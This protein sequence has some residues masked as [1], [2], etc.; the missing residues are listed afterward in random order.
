MGRELHTQEDV[1]NLQHDAKFRLKEAWTN[2][3]VYGS[4]IT[5]LIIF[6]CVVYWLTSL[7]YNKEE[8][9]IGICRVTDFVIDWLLFIALNYL[10][11]KHHKEI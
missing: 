1:N 11:K 5:A 4:Y 9:K 10:R 8:I 2:I 3:K 7:V 6:M